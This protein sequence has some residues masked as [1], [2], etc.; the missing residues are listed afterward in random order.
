MAAPIK[1]T[2]P[3]IDLYIKYIKMCICKD[4]DLK[5]MNEQDLYDTASAMNS[6]LENCIGYLEE[7]RTSNAALRDWGDGLDEELE[8]AANRIN[9]LEEK[10]EKLEFSC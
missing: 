3:T 4:R 10:I 9:E 1:I 8:E 5:N 7:M 2:C 6:E